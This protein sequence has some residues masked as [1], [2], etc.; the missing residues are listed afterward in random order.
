MTAIVKGCAAFGA[1]VAALIAAAPASA[2]IVEVGQVEPAATGSCPSPCIAVSRTT[3]YQ[4]KVGTTE[5]VM[6]I[7]ENGR[8]VAWTISLGSPSARQQ[9]FFDRG[10]GGA[11]DAAHGG[12][13]ERGAGGNR[14]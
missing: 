5:R 8:I 12:D 14:V 9:R 2:R 13:G 10:F 1:A 6:R 7:P 11:E 4:A 3:G